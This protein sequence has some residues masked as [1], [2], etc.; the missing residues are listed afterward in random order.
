[1]LAFNFFFLEPVHTLTLADSRNW[2]ALIVFVVTS[3]VV[4]ELATRS[5]RRAREAELLAEHRDVAARARDGRRRARADLGRRRAGAA[6][7]AGGDR[8]RR[9]DAG[10]LRAR[11]RRAARGDDPARGRRG[12]CERAPARAACAGLAARG[13][14]RPRAARAGGARGRGAAPRRCAQDGAAPRGQPRPAHAADGDLDLGGRARAARPRTSTT[15]DRH[16]LLETILAASDRLDHLVGNL[17][18][19]SRL[20]AGAAEPEQRLVELDELVAG[21]LDELGAAGARIEVSL[22]D[23]L[24]PVSVDPHQIQRA[25]V[26]L[27]ENALKYSPPGEPV[28]VQVARDARRGA[29]P[30]DRP[31]AGRARRRARADLRAVRPRRAHGRLARRRA[32]AR[33]RARLRRGERRPRRRSSRGRGRARRSCSRCPASAAV[34]VRGVSGTAR[35]RRRRRAADPARA[36]DEPARR[37]LRGRDGGRRPRGR[38]PPRRC[39][40]RRR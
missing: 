35:A 2:F 40:R 17:L 29:A 25:I 4:S 1:M 11:G 23:D 22:P 5:R 39:G 27:L 7:R 3:V 26:N 20:Q 9:R 13:G 18:D 10:R 36:A 6:R 24:P 12:R 8:A 31:R 38:S 37:R 32:R 16:E 33:D 28:R 14:R 30:R 15:D 19:L 34:E 21:A